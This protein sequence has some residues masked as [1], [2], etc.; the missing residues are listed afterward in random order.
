MPITQRSDLRTCGW[1]LMQI[2]GDV[3]ITSQLPRNPHRGYNEWLGL[4]F[5]VYFFIEDADS[6]AP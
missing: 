2:D 3:R 5:T 6:R 4:E 1:L